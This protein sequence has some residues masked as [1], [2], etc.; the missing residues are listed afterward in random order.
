MLL[1]THFT[2]CIVSIFVL[3]NRITIIQSQCLFGGATQRDICAI[4]LPI[5]LYMDIE[6]LLISALV[7]NLGD[8][9]NAALGNNV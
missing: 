2:S 6:L 9:K 7:L 1:T 4:T 8:A 3:Q 5:R